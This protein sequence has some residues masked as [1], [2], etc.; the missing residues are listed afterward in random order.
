MNELPVRFGTDGVRGPAN[1]AITPEFVVAL[2]RAA[3]RQLGDGP[4]LIGRDPRRSG[5][6]LEAALAAGL[7]A[8]GRD[9]VRVGVT[10]TPALAW[11]A[12][13][14]GW[15]AAM[16]S[17]S[18][19]AFGDNGVK[20]FAPGGTKLDD[21]VEAR[22]EDE[23]A[24]LY[25]ERTAPTVAGVDVGVVDD[26]PDPTSDYLAWL[27]AQLDGRRLDGLHVVVDCANGSGSVFAPTAL[28][29]TGAD[30]TVLAADPDGANINRGVGSTAPEVLARRVV[31]EGADLGLAL[32][33]DADRLV[34]IDDR[35]GVVDGDHLLALFATDLRARGRL[36]DDTVVVTVMTNLG[37]RLAMAEAGIAV[38]ETAVGDRNV[39]VALDANG[40]SL[41]GEQS[42]HLIFRELATTGDGLLCGLLLCDL[43]ARS[44]ERLSEMAAAAMTQLPQVLVNVPADASA[45]DV[46][47]VL[48]DELA[49]VEG[50]LGDHGR[51]LVRPS[52]TEP[53]VRV[54]VEAPTSAQA[55]QAAE[56]LAG[57]LRSAAS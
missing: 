15:A 1:T 23:L 48:A 52:G 17:A 14:H 11:L 40:W 46:D 39:L 27:A 12:A 10:S 29:A 32:D 9:V 5:S 41:G 34:A 35:G 43:V 31:E 22:L 38:V 57:V 25:A 30:V 26:H 19:N 28:R 47:A 7:A 50:E 3:G 42:G 2:G 45:V 33:G 21:D 24:V 6:L 53:V 18:H 55:E 16:L 20:L 49:A 54:M 44:G 8:E 37:F 13:T 4:V 51:V 36:R 56:R